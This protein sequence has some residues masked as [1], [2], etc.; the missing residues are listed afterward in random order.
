MEKLYKR[1][2]ACKKKHPDWGK[3]RVAEELGTTKSKVET[4]FKWM[5]RDGEWPSAV[6]VPSSTS[7]SSKKNR[8]GTISRR[9]LQAKYDHN[10]K[11]REGIRAGVR[12][13]VNADE[14]E[15]DDVIADSDFRRE[16]CGNVPTNGYRT[17]AN[18]DEFRDYQF[19]VRGTV[20]WT[21][22][23]TKKWALNNISTAR[24]V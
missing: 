15:D 20:Y 13:L 6:P 9:A 7:K 14:P 23:R 24:E 11:I 4:R 5:Q 17:I 1:V 16:R 10:T 8:R 18:E 3:I 21:T 12:T 22:R 2:I 19:L